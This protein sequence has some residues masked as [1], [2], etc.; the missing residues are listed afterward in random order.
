MPLA[1][2]GVPF[3]ALADCR[4]FAVLGEVD[5]IGLPLTRTQPDQA[6]LLVLAHGLHPEAAR[7]AF[8]AL[9]PLAARAIRPRVLVGIA[10]DTIDG[11]AFAGVVKT[12]ALE[13]S[14][15]WKCVTLAAGTAPNAVASEL[16][17]GGNDREV[18]LG[19]E[20]E[21]RVRVADALGTAH[22][23]LPAGPWIVSGGARGVTADCVVELVQAGARTI[24]LLGRTP[25][26]RDDEPPS[27]A[28]ATTEAALKRAL[29]AQA[30]AAPDLRSIN[31]RA[32]AIL[33]QREVRRTLAAIASAGAKG[34]YL[35]IDVAS[36][37]DVAGAVTE[38]RRAWGPIRGLVHAAGVLADKRIGE[39]TL[40]QFDSVMRTKVSGAEALFAACENDPLDYVC[41]FSSVAAHSGNAGQSDYAA[42][43][44]ALEQMVIDE[45]ARR[46]DDCRVVSIAWGPWAG[47][48]VTESLARHFTER[49]VSLIPRHA[50]AAAFVA[51]L[52]SGVQ[53]H[54]VL[55]C[56]LDG[57]DEPA[58]TRIRFDTRSLP[59][60]ID[61]RIG[62]ALVLPMTLALDTLLGEGRRHLG[63]DCEARDLRVLQG[64][65]LDVE[66]DDDAQ[67]EVRLHLEAGRR[68]FLASLVHPSGRPAYN[69]KV[70]KP[71]NEL[72]PAAG[73]LP[74]ATDIPD[75]CRQPYDV[76]LFHGP[77]FQVI[78]EV[79]VCDDGAISARL[80][81]ARGMDWDGTWQL[82]PA[83]LDGA[84]Q[85]L[86]LWGV[87][88]DGR[89]TLPTSI[90]RCRPWT[91]W[92]EHAEVHCTISCRVDD[93][94]RISGDALFVDATSGEPLLSLDGI[95]MHGHT[96]S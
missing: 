44:A 1:A 24:A 62:D 73:P 26:D 4:T 75:V 85:L 56:G 53:T 14:A 81:T 66:D 7:T 20:R 61:H 16:A 22:R 88:Q 89:I 40:E 94:F 18:R 87:A 10:A 19:A 28:A 27:I 43:N 67:V 83:A 12:A 58:E 82:D 86:R 41:A 45:H 21:V 33:A 51:E 42:A 5:P 64:I 32:S 96:R 76:A 39:K 13:W 52:R 46:G 68:G 17:R 36:E 31:R 95:V 57:V 48:M 8:A 84:L 90:A 70:M 38:I 69:V 54:V 9:T 11:A 91:R 37:D 80:A 6:D 79:L 74:A 71:A 72:P 78:R 30:G 15:S 65:V 93:G 23:Q 59:A 60:L 25:L 35:A 49:G 2:S 47:G 63:T 29:I 92:P 55:G 34:R 77:R 3:P 50:G